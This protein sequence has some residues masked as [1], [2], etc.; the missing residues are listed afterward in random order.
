MLGAED[1]PPAGDEPPSAPPTGDAPKTFTQ[2]QLDEIISRRVASERAKFADYD[3]AKAAQVELEKI[4][5][6]N[7]S[8][9][10]KAV[11]RAK[12]EGISEA[13][14]RSNQ[15]LVAAAAR[16][17]AADAK[18]HQPKDAPKLL[19]LSGVKV[20]DDGEVDEDAIKILIDDAVKERGY[21]VKSDEKPAPPKAPRHNPSQGNAGDSTSSVQAGLDAYAARKAAKA[22]PGAPTNTH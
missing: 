11:A 14:T 19:D 22:R 16:A 17:L 3:T 20:S 9:L 13:T 10:D 8:E 21:L 6:D 4:R 12:A 18:F 1:A 15:R 7:A 2:A 5:Q